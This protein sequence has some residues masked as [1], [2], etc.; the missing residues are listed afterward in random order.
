ME[1]ALRIGRVETGK[2]HLF[3]TRHI[4]VSNIIVCCSIKIPQTMKNKP[5]QKY[6]KYVEE[7]SI[8]LCSSSL[9]SIKKNSWN[10]WRKGEF[11]ESAVI[12]ATFFYQAFL[13]TLHVV[14]IYSGL[15]PS[16]LFWGKSTLKVSFAFK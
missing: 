11:S 6:S 7:E 4:I 1:F 9:L 5:D 15:N 16:T 13:Y 14:I 12:N 10:S 2:S 3:A 8:Y